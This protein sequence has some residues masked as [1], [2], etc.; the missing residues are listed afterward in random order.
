MTPRPLS[1]GITPPSSLLRAHAS[2]RNPPAAYGRCLGRRILAGCC[3]PLLGDGPSRRYLR[4]SFPRCLDPY[5]GG[6]DGAHARFFPSGIGLRHVASGSA[7]HHNPHHDFRAD[8]NFGAAVI[9]L[10][11]GPWVCS[12]PRSFPPLCPA[13]FAVT[14][15]SGVPSSRFPLALS[16]APVAWSPLSH[17]AAVAFPSEHIAA[18]YLTAHRI[19]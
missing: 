13:S 1:A 16:P 17:R 3:Q 10:P 19:C 11:S 7:T 15:G 9:R 18:R 2:V 4:K 5:P 14:L 6:P 12:P 8:P